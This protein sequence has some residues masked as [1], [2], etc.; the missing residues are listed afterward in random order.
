MASTEQE[1]ISGNEE[2]VVSATGPRKTSSSVIDSLTGQQKVAALLVAMGKPAAAK[3]LKHFSPDDLRRLSGQAHTL[4]N[5]SLADFD[6]LVHQFE[7]AFAE[8][9]SFSQAGERFDNLVQET[10]PEDEAAKILD[11][12][13]TPAIPEESLWEIMGKMS[14]EELQDH[15][16]QEHPQVIAYI[17]SKLPSDLAAK[18]LLLQTMA[19]RG[20]IIFR[21]LHLRSVMPI[22]D[23]LL[24][25]ALRPELMQKNETAD[26]SHYGE[27]ANILNQLDKSEIDEML[28]SLDGLD[29]EDLEKIKSKLFVFEDI[30]RLSAR[31]RL[32]LFDDIPADVIITALRN[33]DKETTETILGS[34]SQR[35]RRMVEAELKSPN[36]MITQADIT[37]AR[38]TIAQQAIKLSSEGKISLAA[39]ETANGAAGGAPDGDQK[40]PEGDTKEAEKP[41]E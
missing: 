40:A 25:K 32:L 29:P 19:E 34:L 35:S 16:S 10:L 20:D 41:K 13:A 22:V 28:A 2:P 6:I 27:I 11:P 17:V 31:A 18:L 23:E 37:N 4:P 3:I 30:P 7:D 9:V 38:R 33:A 39:D 8:G 36:D 26:Q 15:L 12:N 21:T 14:A 24:D 5:I 1:K